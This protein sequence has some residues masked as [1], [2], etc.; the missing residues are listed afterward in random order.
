MTVRESPTL[1]GVAEATWMVT[2][3]MVVAPFAVLTGE[4]LATVRAL[5]VV[6]SVTE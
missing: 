4:T 3:P 1:K 5:P 2:P 6:A